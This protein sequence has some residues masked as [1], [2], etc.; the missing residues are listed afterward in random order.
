ME[1]IEKLS[2]MIEEEMEDAEKYI[3]CALEKKEAYP[4]LANTFYKLSEEEM[5]HMDML[6]NE[7]T[8]QINQ[9]KSAKGEPPEHMLVLY[10][11]LHRKHIAKATAIKAMQ[12]MYKQ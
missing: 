2:D 6:H 5:R 11:I 7:V 1:I 3:R 9:Y 10:D 4:A 12:A 8:T